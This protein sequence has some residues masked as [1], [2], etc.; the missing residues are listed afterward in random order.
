MWPP[1]ATRCQALAGRQTRRSASAGTVAGIALIAILPVAGVGSAISLLVVASGGL[2]GGRESEPLRPV[3]VGVDRVVVAQVPV[4]DPGVSQ[5][6]GP[7][8]RLAVTVA[9][10]RGTG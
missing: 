5:R 4:V 7:G 2:A 10:G 3:G 8:V 9:V 6:R 1:E